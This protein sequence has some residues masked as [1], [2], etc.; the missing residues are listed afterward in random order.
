[1]RLFPISDLHLER[2]RL[3]VIPRPE[4]P[5]DVLK[6]ARREWRAAAEAARAEA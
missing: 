1:M 4:Q 5:F 6:A 2:R 3:D